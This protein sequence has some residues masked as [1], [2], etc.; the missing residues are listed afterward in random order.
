[1]KLPYK[2][3]LVIGLLCAV[4]SFGIRVDA[5]SPS[6][7][8][9]VLSADGEEYVLEAYGNTGLTPI[10]RTGKI[11]DVF[12]ILN[13]EKNAEKR[14]VL[15]DISVKENIDLDGGRYIL[16]GRL[17]MNNGV[18]SIHSGSVVIENADFD[19]S[20]SS[21]VRHKNGSLV[22]KSGS[23]S[24]ENEALIMDYS[25]GACF[26]MPGGEIRSEHSEYAVGV[27]LGKAHI[28]GGKIISG[29]D[30]AVYSESSLI[31]TGAPI[32]EGAAF[33]IGTSLPITLSEGED[34]FSGNLSVKYERDFEKGNIYPV[35]YRARE[36]SLFGISLFDKNETEQNVKYFET[37]PS[38]SEKRFVAV[39]LPHT[40][41]YYHGGILLETCEV[42][43]GMKVDRLSPDDI[44]GYSFSG[45][46]SDKNGGELFDFEKGITEDVTLYSRYSLKAPEF[47]LNSFSATYKNDVYEVGFESISHP[48]IESALITYEWYKNGEKIN[49]A[50]EAVSLRYVSDSGVYKCKL[51]FSYGNDVSEVVTPEVE[52]IINKAQIN[53]PVIPQKSYTGAYLTPD[54]YSTY[55]YTVSDCQALKVGA[56]PVLFTLTDKENYEFERGVDRVFRDFI[57]T[58][59]ENYFTEELKV[60]NIYEGEIPNP[61]A[62]TRFGE[63]EY[64]FSSEI[65]GEYTTKIPNLAGKY[66]CVARVSECE[67][68]FSLQSE[69]YEFLIKEEAI[70][71]LSLNTPPAKTVYRAFDSFLSDGLFLLATYNSGKTE[72][73]G[74]DKYEISYQKSNTLRY[75][76]NAVIASFSGMKILVP[77]TVLKAQYDIS[78]ISFSDCEFVY[79]GEYQAPDLKGNLPI[80]IDGIPLLYKIVGGGRDSGEY[81]AVLTFFSESS[82]YEIPSELSVGVKILPYEVAPVFIGT[83]FVYDGELKAPLAYYV[84]IGGRKVILSVEGAASLAGEYEAKVT[85]ADKNYKLLSDTVSFKIAKADYDFSGVFWTC[86][87]FVYDSEEKGVFIEGLPSGVRVIGYS[88][89]K[90]SLAGKYTA[91][92][93]LSYDTLN[94]NPPPTL[95]H[96][97]EIKK[98][99]YELDSF[100]FENSKNVYDGK[101]HY[102]DLVGTLPTGLDG[103][104]LEYSFSG[105]AK[106]VSEGRVA[107]EVSFKTESKNYNVPESVIA[108]VEIEPVGIYV[109]WENEVFVY[110]TYTSCP[111][112]YSS[113]TA[114][115]VLG[116]AKN[117]GNYVATALSV[118]SNYYVL[119]STFNF[120][121]EKAENYWLSRLDIKDAF[122]G[123]DL[124]PTAKA[125]AGI[126]EFRYTDKDG[127]LL[128][129]V[130]SVP[131]EYYVFAVSAGNENYKEIKSE[132]ILFEIIALVPT[133][134]EIE[135]FKKEFFAFEKLSAQDLSVSVSFNDGTKRKIAYG[136]FEIIYKNADSL[137]FSDSDVKISVLGI[138]KVLRVSVLKANYDMKSVYWENTS[139]IYDGK[140]KK[141]TLCG[142]P[143]GVYVLEYIGGVGISAGT[144]EASAI[145]MYDA[146]N[147]NPPSVPEGALVIEK[148]VVPLPKIENLI[149]CGENQL[150]EIENSKIYEIMASA[151]KNAGEYYLTLKILDTDNYRFDTGE[152]TAILG[153][154][155]L[156]KEITLILSG[157][158]K[159]LFSSPKQPTYTVEGEI[160][161]GDELNLIFSYKDGVV[162]CTSQNPNY[163][164]L[165]EGGKIIKH[166]SIS[167]EG[168]LVLFFILLLVILVFLA[169]WIIIRKRSEIYNYLLLIKYKSTA[170]DKGTGPKP[171]M[172]EKY[173]IKSSGEALD[174]SMSVDRERAD[175]LISDALAKELVRRE[176]VKI[177]TNGNKKGI[178]NIDTINENFQSG[179]KVDVNKLKEM[180]LI[181]Y[182]TAYIKVL[183]RGMIDKPLFVFA[184]DFS[185]SAVKMIALTGGEANR[186]IT[187]RKQGNKDKKIEKSIEK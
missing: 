46:G 160:Y 37:H 167:K 114:I 85:A 107:V 44:A 68:Y 24:S 88:N 144:Y 143:G 71:N 172:E 125:L 53:V 177:Y 70:V 20:E 45:W 111:S 109:S 185:L 22:L 135:L 41:N 36:A 162:V 126:T 134:V 159:Y 149:Y 101:T 25:S 75:G 163:T 29:G 176:S 98:A 122:E 39:Y 16:T 169:V 13:L 57:I 180:S 116:G 158:D 1:M 96:E 62:S 74:A 76:D 178:I 40:V 52:F 48:L 113:L 173:E 50:G 117:A 5:A 154:K 93:S 112:A 183:A 184:N 4:V 32:F 120:S 171:W 9:Y 17:R 141:I 147:Y 186:C 104:G 47:I 100:Y 152:D 91:S 38:V 102:P 175:S 69:P 138:E 64:L 66:Y 58:K 59:A 145:L 133:D 136:D 27:Y 103:I 170:K 166:N 19:L 54:V 67:D 124:V 21:H 118:D 8:E 181:P 123:Y 31:L 35:F 87:S 94:Y 18:I 30:F 153:Y 110:N 49:A 77:I 65:D 15:R 33:G 155:I 43:S 81:R 168:V 137:R 132:R 164:V 2:I 139:H 60:A 119:N 127:N 82:D 115:E 174:A 131:G 187:V 34:I 151:E 28:S 80:G 73:I 161:D 90:N 23:I 6:E 63:I 140:E 14:V 95:F 108:Y 78:G 10:L 51:L 7:A 142:L 128:E 89:H 92:V 129:K 148:A 121:I 99:D 179:D 11:S 83:D 12:E 26:E 106:N 97:W 61:R 86:D 79:S 42:L 56:Y 55:L 150:P 146:E 72:V 156:P 3:M 165:T 105:G 157:V 84:D 130:P 182:D